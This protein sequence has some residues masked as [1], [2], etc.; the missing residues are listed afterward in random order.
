LPVSGIYDDR[1]I[2]ITLDNLKRIPQ[3]ICI[4]GGPEKREALHG[5]LGA[6]YAT[7]FV[8][9]ETSAAALLG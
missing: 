8:T 6:G 1:L 2:G 5:V 7:H 9:D 4:A 3:R